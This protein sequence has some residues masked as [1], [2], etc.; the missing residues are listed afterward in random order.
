[1]T[2]SFREARF[3]VHRRE[4]LLHETTGEVPVDYGNLLQEHL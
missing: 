2:D 4:A 3:T 1:M